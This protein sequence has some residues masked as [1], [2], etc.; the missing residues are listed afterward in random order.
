MKKEFNYRIEKASEYQDKLNHFKGE[1]E[2][3]FRPQML[4]FTYKAFMNAWGCITNSSIPGSQLGECITQKFKPLQSY[5]TDREKTWNTN[6]GE[7]IACINKCGQDDAECLSTCFN[8]MA[9]KVFAEYQRPVSYTHLTLPT[10]Y[11]V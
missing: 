8:G 10:T 7:A 9:N 5:W 1:M 2:E 6:V 3:T 4:N 11:S